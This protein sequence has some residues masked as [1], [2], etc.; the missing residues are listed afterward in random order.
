M[1][2][3]HSQKNK[4]K[5]FFKIALIVFVVLVALLWL[6]SSVNNNSVLVPEIVIIPITG[7]IGLESGG[8]LFGGGGLSADEIVKQI[9]IANSNKHVAAIILELNTPGGTV[10]A[11]EDI[12]KA[13]EKSEKPVVAWM[14]EIATSGGYWIAASTDE[15]IADP[16]SITGSIGVTGSYLSFEG[17][18]NEYGVKYERLV[19]GPYKDTGTPF[20]NL[21]AQE[22]SL[23]QGKINYINE[24]FI[25]HVSQSRG[26]DREDVKRVATGEIFLG[27]E[28]LNL[29]LV[30]KLGSKDE[31]VGSAENLAGIDASR[32]VEYRK[33]VGIL[34][35]LSALAQININIESPE[36][37]FA[38]KS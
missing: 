8:G 38:I 29:G 33:S 11:S 35:R 25:D 5:G 23:M 24:L 9:E 32:T 6:I 14:R 16:A 7:E 1:V 2:T 10:V 31:A 34:E 19:S 13:V 26:M 22:Q 15:I 12:A 37:S 30:D 27:S 28:A 3:I 20:R 18:F 21:T 36:Q 4:R 17:L